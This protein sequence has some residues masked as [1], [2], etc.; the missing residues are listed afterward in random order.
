MVME[1]SAVALNKN[2][3]LSVEGLMV[4]AVLLT[5]LVEETTILV[6]LSPA[7]LA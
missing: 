6:A 5:A 2:T 1:P 3:S 7:W 4:P